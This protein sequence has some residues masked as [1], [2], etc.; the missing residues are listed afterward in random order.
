[1]T[2]RFTIIVLLSFTVCAQVT[3][4]GCS[5][6]TL[7]PSFP[8]HER[9]ALLHMKQSFHI[10]CSASASD[11]AAYPKLLSWDDVDN[12]CL[13]DGV[14]C[15]ENTGHVIGLDLSSSCLRGTFTG[16]N[17]VFSLTH[18]ESL[19]LAFNDFN[20]S[21]IPSQIG[22]FVIGQIPL[23][24]SKLSRLSVLDLSWNGRSSSNTQL[25]LRLEDPSLEKIVR[26]LTRITHLNLALVDVS[27]PVPSTLANLT[28]LKAITLSLCNLYGE[29]P[30]RIFH[31][32]GLE[33]LRLDGNRDLTGI[34]PRFDFNSALKDLDL[35]SVSF[36]GELPPSIGNLAS[37]ERLELMNCNLTGLIPSSLGNLT[38]LSHLDLSN[39][40]FV[41]D[42]PFSVTNLTHLRALDISN[43]D[44][45]LVN[46]MSQLPKLHKL[47]IL[48]LAGLNLAG[49]IPSFL[50]N[51]TDLGFLDLNGNRLTGL[52]PH[53]FMNL[54]QLTN[55][56]LKDNQLQGPIPNW[57]SW[58]SNM[59]SLEMSYNNLFGTI[60]PFLNLE[61][62]SF[63]SLDGINLTFSSITNTSS[64]RLK[65]SVLNL[66]SCNLSEFPQFLG[67]QDELRVLSLKGNNIR[68]KIPEWFVNITRDTLLSINL[69]NNNLTGFEKRTLVLPRTILE[70]LDLSSNGFEGPLPFPPTRSI[71]MYTFSDNHLTGEFPEDFCGS[72]SLIL[73]DLSNNNMSS[74]IPPCVGYRL[75]NTLQALNLQGNNFHGTIPQTFKKSC[76]LKMINLSQNR[77]EGPLPKSLLNC[78]MLVV[79]NVGKNRLSNA[80]PTWLGSL[81]DLQVIVLNHNNFYGRI[82]GPESDLNF[83][84]LRSID[85]SYNHL[86]GDLPGLLFRKWPAMRVPSEDQTGVSKTIINFYL[87]MNEHNDMFK[88]SCKLKMINLSQNRLEGPLPKSLLNCTMLE[89]L[90][91]G[92]N[93]LSDAFSTWLGS[94][95]DLQV[96]VLNHNNFYGRITGPESDLNFGKL[97]IIDLSYN[98]LTGDLPALL[99]RQWP[100]TRVPSEDQS[101][102]SKTIIN[103]YLEMNE[104]SFYYAE[105]TYNYSITITDK[106][107]ER[108]FSRVSN[109]LSSRR[110]LE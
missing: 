106:G 37:L 49:E 8:D 47:V 2:I 46:V 23:E 61:K 17:T 88:K 15:N 92:K 104:Q 22:Q 44:I 36:S 107:R 45:T 51:F 94:L 82:T 57:F 84:K 6:A 69:S 60:E 79:L 9:S 41:G 33:T 83:G 64:S 105:K 28:Y 20:Y 99:F 10:D 56:Y 4:L 3:E 96:I 70:V 103:F 90:D 62:L 102:A 67:S 63:L 59:H 24:I 5:F 40:Y 16:S 21:N 50:A 34:L 13:W 52:L 68:G 89:V 109:C 48:R 14:E 101:G 81:H 1:M 42:F 80:F 32:P 95:R 91:A 26:N 66:G 29:F 12:C 55:L 97:R 7:P 85:L 72:S 73:L 31:L 27:S 98:C 77:L 19:N 25:D 100:A 38:K 18:L 30:T 58:L 71:M 78:T 11:P 93:R 39:N 43:L 74:R 108:F 35:F 76:K 53:W 75:G 87:E 54:T 86:T 110:L 65:L